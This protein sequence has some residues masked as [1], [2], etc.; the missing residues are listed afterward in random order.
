MGW[1]Y[2]R[3]DPFRLSDGGKIPWTAGYIDPDSVVEV[4]IVTGVEDDGA[5]DCDP[6]GFHSLEGALVFACD[7]SG[8]ALERADV[9]DIDAGQW[10]DAHCIGEWRQGGY[11]E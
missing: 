8:A 6:C 5:G 9:R 11:W 2:R 7:A 10:H 3:I 4:R 1:N